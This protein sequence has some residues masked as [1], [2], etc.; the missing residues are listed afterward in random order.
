MQIKSIVLYGPQGKIRTLNFRTGQV[1]VVTGQSRTGKS[2]LIDIVDYCLGRST[3]NVFEGV[4]RN[5]VQWY[6]VLLEFGSTEVFIAKPPPSGVAHSQSGAFLRV[7][8]ALEF[9]NIGE[10]RINSSDEA[11]ER[12]LSSLLRLNGN[13]NV[14]PDGASRDPLQAN[15]SHAKF[16]VFQEQGEVANKKFLFHRQGEQFIPQAIKDTLPYFLGAVPEDRVVLLAEARELRRKIKI[17]SRRVSENLA[18]QGD[19]SA[20][21]RALLESAR[22]VG[23]ESTSGTGSDLHSQLIGLADWRPGFERNVPEGSIDRLQRDL[24]AARK[25]Y[26]QTLEKL[27]A[28]RQFGLGSRQFG[29]EA[30]EQVQRL[31]SLNLFTPE[32]DAESVCPLCESKLAGQLPRVEDLE[33]NLAGL[34]KDLKDVISQRPQIDRYVE[35]LVEEAAQQKQQI[36]SLRSLLEVE[37][38]QADAAEEIQGINVQRALVVG[39][40]HMFLESVKE[41]QPDTALSAELESAR[42]ELKRVESLLDPSAIEEVVDSMLN[43]IGASMTELAA[44]LKLEFGGSLYRLDLNKLTVVADTDRPI[45]MDRMG[46]AENWLGCHLAAHLA[47]HKHFIRQGRPVPRFLFLDQPSQVYF[48]SPIAYSALD[49][50]VESF[51]ESD[52]DAQAVDRMFKV[53]FEACQKLSPDFQIIVTEH[54]NLPSA[55]Y[56]AALADKPWRDGHALIPSDWLE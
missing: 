47:L 23:L 2:A 4:N 38:A 55:E 18:V 46:S 14:P 45:P 22:L 29:D 11:V 40:I 53:L 20:R 49:G 39:K 8:S 42:I 25:S 12:Y 16:F 28:A 30:Q 5:V 54:A 48:P 36:N 32:G 6:A 9:P 56:Q 43:T 34:A 3:F 19:E 37:V 44:D 21:T 33:R 27:E 35:Q 24:S 1:N 31:T 41:I 13:I 50:S 10:L 15:L 52:A 26:Q 7:G 51:S 17:L